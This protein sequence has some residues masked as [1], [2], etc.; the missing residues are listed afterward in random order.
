MPNLINKKKQLGTTNI[1]LALAV[2]LLL[3]QLRRLTYSLGHLLTTAFGSAVTLALFMYIF[4][5]FLKEKLP[6]INMT[7]AEHVRFY[8]TLLMMMGSGWAIFSW[9]K[10]LLFGENSWTH[11]LANLGIQQTTIRYASK[12]TVFVITLIANLATTMLITLSFGPLGA[13]HWLSLVPI[14]LIS[15]FYASSAT[16]G[17]TK[18]TMDENLAEMNHYSFSLITWRERRFKGIRW[19]GSM[20]CMMAGLL[21]LIGPASILAGK[22]LELSLLSSLIGGIILSWVVPSAIAEDLRFTWLER[23][24]AI[25]HKQWIN[26][27]QAIFSK[28][29]VI[30]F[31]VS[32]IFSMIFGLMTINFTLREPVPP[33]LVS[34][35]TNALL[36]G[37]LAAFP[38]WLA[39]SF[40]LQIDGRKITTNILMLTIISLFVGTAIIAIPILIP[41][42]WLLRHEAHRYQ[43]GR[44]ARASYY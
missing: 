28:W 26:A 12:L 44:F 36:A 40:V 18:P 19:R 16:V 24:A 4:G 39:P 31:A 13:A 15:T 43:E 21:F 3:Q 10:I 5:D 6:K 29:S 38:V 30:C 1:A 35:M 42:I 32:L 41:G 9:C 22:P 2:P 33:T 11:Y 23:Q 20:L 14:V 37:V 17:A 25:S 27:W 7:A 34:I 8:F